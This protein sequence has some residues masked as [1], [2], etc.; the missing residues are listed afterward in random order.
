MLEYDLVILA[1]PMIW[2][3]SEALRYGFRRGE[4]V[5]LAAAFAVPVLFKFTLLQ[6]VMKLSGM[7]AAALLFAMV[8]RRMTQRQDDFRMSPWSPSMAPLL[9]AER[10]RMRQRWHLI[11]SD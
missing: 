6:N 2:L 10:S 5:A 8:L 11:S 4:A 7:A 9:Q 3:L 1:V